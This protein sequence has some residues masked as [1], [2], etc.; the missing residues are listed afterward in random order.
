MNFDFCGNNG[1]NMDATISCARKAQVRKCSLK[2]GK[3]NGLGSISPL[4]DCPNISTK[5]AASAASHLSSL[6]RQS[7]GSPAH[8]SLL[9]PNRFTGPKIPAGINGESRGGLKFF[10]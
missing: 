5:K 8:H 4:P 7:T 10:W 1:N 2:F 3:R 9:V 6:T